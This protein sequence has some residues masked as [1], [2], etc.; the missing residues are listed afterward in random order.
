MHGI[1]IDDGQPT[2]YPGDAL[3]Q[4][5]ADGREYLAA[6]RLPPPR[7]PPLVARLDRT[8]WE[9]FTLHEGGGGTGEVAASC[10]FGING[11]R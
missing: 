3:V 8:S 2:R 6:D 4:A 11:L 5:D 10:V 9:S 7:H 1:E